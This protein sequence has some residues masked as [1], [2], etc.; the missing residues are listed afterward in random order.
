MM[1]SLDANVPTLN[2]YSGWVPPDWPFEL[3][4]FA[5]AATDAREIE[6]HLNA[7]CSRNGWTRSQVQ[8]IRDRR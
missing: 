6:Q 2:G 1:A 7:W 4:S 3:D 8:W 5:D